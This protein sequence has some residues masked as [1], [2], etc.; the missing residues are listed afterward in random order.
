MSQTPAT[1]RNP[2]SWV[3]TGY[4]AEGIPY[5]MI[6]WVAA[7]IELKNI[8]R[9]VAGSVTSASMRFV[10]VRKSPLG[11]HCHVVPAAAI[12]SSAA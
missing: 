4:F 9:P 12:A 2:W 1:A 10:T 5:V 11:S 7:T 3:P 6:T 8:S